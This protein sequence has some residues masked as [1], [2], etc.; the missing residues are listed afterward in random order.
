[1]M[2]EKPLKIIFLKIS[3]IKRP[4]DPNP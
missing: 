4:D 2:L 3:R 1:M